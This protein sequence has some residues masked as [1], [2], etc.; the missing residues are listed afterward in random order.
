MHDPWAD[1]LSEYLD[2]ELSPA[3]RAALE[4]HLGSCP[5]CA[6][7][8]AD[9]ERVVARAASLDDRPPERDLW[10]AIAARISAPAAPRVIELATRIPAPP[11]R[12]SFTAGQLVAAALALVFMS[13][14][15]VWL[16]RQPPAPH[17]AAGPVPAG[18]VAGT[19][20]VSSTWNGY[21]AAIAD[22]ERV[23]DLHREQLDSATV[24][25]LEENLRIIDAAIDEARRALE[26]DPANSY[27]NGHLVNSMQRKLDLLRRVAALASVAT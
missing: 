2:D 13:G 1:R 25:V 15:A 20:F 27:L 5:D 4:A 18:P 14:G 12:F 6:A 17:A 7:T 19:S 21:D 8:L 23:L 22:L 3:E 26:A 16:L 24:R 10:P 9:L 11:R